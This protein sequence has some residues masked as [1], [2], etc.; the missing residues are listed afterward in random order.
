[1]QERAVDPVVGEAEAECGKFVLN[2]S[3]RSARVGKNDH[4]IL[5]KVH[6]MKRRRWNNGNS[7]ELGALGLRLVIDNELEIER[8]R[9]QCEQRGETSSVADQSA[10]SQALEVDV[11]V[12]SQAGHTRFRGCP[13]SGPTPGAPTADRRF[14]DTPSHAA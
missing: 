4:G 13:R 8:R 3:N 1:M 6:S 7:Q 14:T 5:G 10:A 9:S 12:A 2:G 11:H